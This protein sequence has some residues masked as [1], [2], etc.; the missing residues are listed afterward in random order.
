MKWWFSR[1][2][3]PCS[4]SSTV[5]WRTLNFWGNLKASEYHSSW[6]LSILTLIFDIRSIKDPSNSNP[7]KSWTLIQVPLLIADSG[8]TLKCFYKKGKNK[9]INYAIPP[10]TKNI[11]QATHGSSPLIFLCK[12]LQMFCLNRIQIKK[13]WDVLN[14]IH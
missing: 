11:D 6:Y 9:T 14:Y 3:F 7:S 8:F 10:S 1:E 13:I 4:F 5:S 12:I 2:I